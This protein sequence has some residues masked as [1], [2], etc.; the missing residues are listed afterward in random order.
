MNFTKPDWESYIRYGFIHFN[1]GVNQMSEEATITIPK[2]TLE[3]L[4]KLAEEG[5]TM[6][7]LIRR[8]IETAVG[9]QRFAQELD[10]LIEAEESAQF[11]DN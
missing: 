3:E 10:K 2:E 9:V 1:T 8:L 7:Q 4:K 11:D 5:E 6:D